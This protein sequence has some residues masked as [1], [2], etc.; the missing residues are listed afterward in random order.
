MVADYPQVDIYPRE[1]TYEPDKYPMAGMTSHLV[2]VGVYD[3]HT[4]NT[5]YL[6]AGDPTNRYFTN[7]AW[8][9]DNKT[10]YMFELNRAQNDCRLVAYD[11]ETGDKIAELYHGMLLSLS[12]KARKTAITTYIYMRRAVNS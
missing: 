7:M 9:P 6:K 2:T 11:A 10:I 5:I 1:A 3:L 12:C 4:Q 8:S